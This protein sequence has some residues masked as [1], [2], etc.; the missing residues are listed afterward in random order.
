MLTR[1][2]WDDENE[3][4]TELIRDGRFLNA[5][6]GLEI[7]RMIAEGLAKGLSNGGETNEQTET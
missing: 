4:I 7:G 3:V 5:K 1:E 2:E 6:Q